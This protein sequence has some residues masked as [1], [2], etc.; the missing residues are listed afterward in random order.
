MVRPIDLYCR[1]CGA[2]LSSNAVT[3]ERTLDAKP[4][5]GRGG[6]DGRTGVSSPASPRS[7]LTTCAILVGCFLL[8]TIALAVIY[9][10]LLA[11]QPGGRSAIAIELVGTSTPYPT[12]KPYSTALPYKTPTPYPTVIPYPTT[13]ALATVAPTVSETE[14]LFVFTIPSFNFGGCRLDVK[15]QYTDLDSVVVLANV[16]TNA[17]VAA[18]YVRAR[19]SFSSSG[20]PTGTYYTYVA[21]GQDWEPIT[22]RF[23]HNA[24]YLRFKEPV[25]FDTCSSGF[26]GSYQY[27]EITLHITEGSGSDTINVQ[28]DNFPRLSP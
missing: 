17:S 8:L 7:R 3:E 27:L 23:I 5:T 6:L 2:S 26:F 13:G 11:N 1:K 22:G 4:E 25:T 21:M 24:A 20:I 16:D 18:V 12:R 19:D 9:F 28:P 14:P 15:N 10:I